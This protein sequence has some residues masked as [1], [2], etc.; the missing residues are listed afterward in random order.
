MGNHRIPDISELPPV[1]PEIDTFATQ[2]VVCPHCGHEHQD[3]F[4]F[5]RN[6]TLSFNVQAECDKCEKIFYF[7]VE[8]QPYYYS[9]KE[10]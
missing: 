7:D 2:E 8:F 9:R 6:S 3:S 4:E 10:K 1:L 5:H